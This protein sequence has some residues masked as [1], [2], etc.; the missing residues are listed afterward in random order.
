MEK[1]DPKLFSFGNVISLKT[2]PAQVTA[3]SSIYQSSVY[4]SEG[5]RGGDG[6]GVGRSRVVAK[7]DLFRGQTK[8]LKKKVVHCKLSHLTVW[9]TRS[10][11][12]V[13]I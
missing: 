12:E 13:L 2:V 9:Y 5:S 8:S 1:K 7:S 3:N 11:P 6:Q 4:S 10:I